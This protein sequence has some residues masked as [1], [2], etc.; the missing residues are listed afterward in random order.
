MKIDIFLD[1]DNFD[2]KVLEMN[3]DEKKRWVIEVSE[4]NTKAEQLYKQ[5][6]ISKIVLNRV[7]SLWHF[8]PYQNV[9]IMS[10]KKFNELFGIK[11]PNIKYIINAIKKVCREYE[12]R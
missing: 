3:D 8:S 12:E 10:T 4:I 7:K 2:K 6:K 1:L 5:G 11:E 9:N